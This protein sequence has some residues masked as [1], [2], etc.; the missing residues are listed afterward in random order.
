MVTPAASTDEP[1]AT[2]G[3]DEAESAEHAAPATQPEPEPA[4]PAAEEPAPAEQP[5]PAT[6]ADAGPEEPAEPDPMTERFG[7]GA[8]SPRPDGST[9]PGHPI[10]GNADSMLFHTPDSP[11][12]DATEPEVWFSDE[13]TAKAAG[14][15]HWDRTKR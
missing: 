9:P 8:A 13:A 1:P 6:A 15:A 14:F 2:E 11:R 7:P 12:Y 3:H 5:E 4:P 10:K